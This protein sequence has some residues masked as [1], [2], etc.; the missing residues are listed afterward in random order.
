MSDTVKKRHESI[1]IPVL[2][3][4]GIVIFPETIIHF[5]VGCDRSLH[6][7]DAAMNKDQQLF[8]ITQKDPQ[9]DEPERED[10]YNIGTLGTI[11]QILKLPGD[12]MRVLV[13]G[14]A[15]ARLMDLQSTDSCLMGDITVLRTTK[16][17]D[18]IETRALVRSVC[19][20]LDNYAKISGRISPD[21]LAAILSI[22]DPGQL[23]DILA[24]NLLEKQEE[25]QQILEMLKDEDRLSK[26]FSL[27]LR[28]TE[29]AEAEKSVQAHVREQMEQNQRDYY[30]R[31]QIKAIQTE[32]GDDDEAQTEDLR[33]RIKNTPMNDEARDKANR[34]LEKLERMSPGSPEIGLSESYIEWL[35]ALPWGKYTHDQYELN[36][37]RRIL[38]E[39]HYGLQDV[40]ERII[41]YLAICRIRQ[42]I[43]GPILC[44][45]GPPG[46]GKTSIA[47]SIARALGRRF[48]QMSL[49]GVRDEAEIRGHRRTYIGAIPGRIISSIR[50]AGTMNPVFLFDEIDK[51]GSDV[52]GDPASAL[53][54]VL[55]SAQ[56]NTFRDHYIDIPFDLSQVLFI[57]TANTTDTIP[58]P[59][60]DRME[61]IE[62]EG[63]TEED[64]LHIAKQHLLP[65]QI[66]E[67]G[68]KPKSVRMSERVLRC[69]INEY[70]R[71]AGVRIL[72]RTI[73]RLVRKSAVEMVDSGC[74][75]IT[76]DKEKLQQ[77]LGIPIYSFDKAEKGAEVGV[78][79]GLAWTP[80][81]G[82]TLKVEA[83]VMPGAGALELTGSLGDVMKESARAA[84]TWVRAHAAELGIPADFYK[85]QDIHIHVPEGAVPKDGPSAGITITTAL[86]SS[87]TGL[88]VRQNV[89]MTGEVTLRG[90]VLPIGGLKEKLLAAHRA[91]IDTVLIP[92]ENRKDLEKVPANVL[93]ALKIVT[94]SN[95]NEVLPV[96]L[97]G[98]P[99]SV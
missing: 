75:Q 1:N 40:K 7:L 91:G 65:N 18:T 30:L 8:L 6:A 32:L 82:D 17:R 68:L 46:V 45:V 55:D 39:D 73:G 61:V 85:N 76:I 52:R 41:E 42:D 43:H 53:L 86:V 49:G 78:V 71:E 92:K 72:Q 16:A 54:E 62:I 69:I 23:A 64:K 20:A 83:A 14:K 33:E 74:G 47:K 21:T 34:E 37:A 63:Y 99:P 94:V 84:R 31:E 10:L 25:K 89:A 4:R 60:L 22:D 35:L 58:R 26:V 48:V 79:N 19:D 56:N 36:R 27:L 93:D 66:K 2:P 3:L 96:A 59:L 97:C 15:R 24:A 67:H 50:Q 38:E 95:I 88:P 98:F 5:D 44:F 90:R 57:T 70:T 28:E 11:K 81:G 77:Y 9:T 51:V 13:E 29:I 12:R 80:A 87:L